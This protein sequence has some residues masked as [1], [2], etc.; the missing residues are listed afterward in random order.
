MDS[1]ENR[2]GDYRLTE[3]LG[4]DEAG[5]SYLAEHGP[6]GRLC[7]V[8]VLH[9]ALAE[10]KRFAERFRSVAR[11]MDDLEHRRI[12]AV[13][14]MRR[15]EGRY[16]VVMD[17]VTGPRN[18][19]MSLQKYLA[20]RREQ[21]DGTVQDELVRIWSIQIAEALAFA[22]DKGHRHHW[23]RPGK[24]L[25]DSDNNVQVCEVGLAR[26]VGEEFLYSRILHDM[27]ERLVEALSRPRA[28][29]TGAEPG[30]YDYLAPEQRHAAQV[31]ERADVY[32]FGVMLYRMLT[33][34]GPGSLAQP[35]SMLVDDI[36]PQWDAVVMKCLAE[37]PVD[38]YPSVAVLRKAIKALEAQVPVAAP[39]EGGDVVELDAATPAAEVA[40]AAAARA[41]AA[42]GAATPAG[43]EPPPLRRAPR[44]MGLLGKALVFGV[45]FALVFAGVRWGPELARKFT[46]TRGDDET[47]NPVRDDGPG[48]GDV[49]PGPRGRKP[50][51][52]TGRKSSS[53]LF[54]P[55]V[56]G[57]DDTPPRRT[58]KPPRKKPD[59]TMMAAL[60]DQAQGRKTP[61]AKARLIA[62]PKPT[63]PRESA[64]ARMKRLSAMSTRTPDAVARSFMDPSRLKRKTANS[65]ARKAFYMG[66][67]TRE[68]AQK[69]KHYTKAIELDGT[70]AWAYVQRGFAYFFD[71]QYVKA[72]GDYTKAIEIDGDDYVPYYCRALAF[73]KLGRKREAEYDYRQAEQRAPKDPAW[74]IHRGNDHVGQGKHADAIRE[75][76]KAITLAP[77]LALAYNNRGAVYSDQGQ[78]TKALTDLTQAIAL[79]T[80]S[81]RAY[82]NRGLTYL[83]MKRY[84]EAIRDN[85]TALG[86]ESRSA[87]A[88]YNRACA[89]EAKG[90]TDQAER[91]F[92]E[93]RNIIAPKGGGNRLF[94]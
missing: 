26:A 17:Y 38:R 66:Q 9:E 36:M 90:M 71:R 1:D 20:Y 73:E 85:T 81:F 53:E 58:G 47:D 80:N 72:L 94:D 33:G 39:A 34:R 52:K 78:Y 60:R 54:G 32:A 23:L 41:A 11:A 68:P 64:V 82:F 57:P 69:I 13:H 48:P 89:Y 88:Y 14:Q 8:K 46:K 77:K 25:I 49:E 59:K 27:A 63:K 2:I 5:L 83:R 21:G 43:A 67:A 75:Y 92:E 79:D 50:G 55:L 93:A 22:H 87:K 35:P 12:V 45:L 86:I 65:S 37:S 15:V 70:Y 29:Y 91:D 4:E 74:H 28:P 7:V 44:R 3:L 31:D 42:A 56:P 19:P 62:P 10:D 84:D 76:S 16:L 30:P 6:D 24:V 61:A 51:P 40:A 18:E